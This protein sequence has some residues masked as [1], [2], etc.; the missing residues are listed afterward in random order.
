MASGTTRTIQV[1]AVAIAVVGAIWLLSDIVAA[2]FLAVL[3]AVILRSLTNRVVRWAH[4]PVPLALIAVIL[5]LGLVFGWLGYRIAPKLIEESQGLWNSLMSQID[6]LRGSRGPLWMQWIFRHLSSS[7]TLG[8]HLETST[9]TFLAVT[10]RGLLT[11]A[12]LLITAFYFALEPELYLTGVL[13]LLPPGYRPRA[14]SIL[15][16]AGQNLLLWSVGQVIEMGVVGVLAAAGLYLLHVPMALALAVLA[17][18][19]TFIPYFG[20]VMG[21][22]PALM[23]GLSMGWQTFFWVL[24][25]F[26]CCH[27]VDAYLVGPFVQRRTVRLPPAL[28]VLSMTVLGSLFGPLG[29]AIA[30]PLAAVLL[31]VVREGYVVDVL[32]NRGVTEPALETETSRLSE[33]ADTTTVHPSAPARPDVPADSD[34]EAE[35]ERRLPS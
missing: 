28:T 12:V 24:A 7:P 34:R 21:A 30:A 18:L 29:I 16:R 9:G 35:P 19:L 11:L 10:A 31:V 20:P 22:L 23:M 17:G 6:A 27:I 8:T 2:I 33:S 15:E 4:L 13:L 14:R 25:I 26:I 32:E 5:I 1:I 3:L